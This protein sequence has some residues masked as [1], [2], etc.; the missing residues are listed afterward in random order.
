MLL[1]SKIKI[2]IF[3]N[4]AKSAHDLNPIT[5]IVMA[6]NPFTYSMRL[7]ERSISDIFSG[8]TLESSNKSDKF[9]KSFFCKTI[10][11]EVA[12]TISS[13]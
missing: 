4:L 12:D 3:L 7:N 13:L 2:L 8:L 5:Y 9:F 10:F 1:W 11:V 6:Q